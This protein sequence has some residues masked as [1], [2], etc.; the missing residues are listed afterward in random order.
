MLRSGIVP[1]RAKNF[2]SARPRKRIALALALW[3]IDSALISRRS[4]DEQI[5]RWA[6]RL[7]IAIGNVPDS[8]LIQGAAAYNGAVFAILETEL[9]KFRDEIQ[10]N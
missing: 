8:I 4:M 9:D 10:G 2:L 7:N 6:L 3:W 5:K 1:P